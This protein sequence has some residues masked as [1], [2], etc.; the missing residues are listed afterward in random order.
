MQCLSLLSISSIVLMYLMRLSCNYNYACAAFLKLSYVIVKRLRSPIVICAAQ[1]CSVPVLHGDVRPQ[2]RS[3]GCWCL[4]LALPGVAVAAQ[5]LLDPRQKKATCQTG[6]L[7]DAVASQRSKLDI[8]ERTENSSR[9]GNSLWW[10]AQSRSTQLATA[11]PR[12]L[13]K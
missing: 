12:G 13:E 7:S 5:P 9:T 10:N 2:V 6:N 8:P 4:M 11:S 1:Q 3:S